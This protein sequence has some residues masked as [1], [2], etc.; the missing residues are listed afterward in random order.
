MSLL[1]AMA[2]GLPVVTTAEAGEIPEP[3]SA[4]NAVVVEDP[5]PEALARGM[6]KVTTSAKTRSELGRAAS[7]RAAEL[8]GGHALDQL[9]VLDHHHRIGAAPAGEPADGL[10]ALFGRRVRQ[11]QR[12]RRA[13]AL[14]PAQ[15]LLAGD[16]GA[17]LFGDLAVEA[18][19][20]DGLK[21]HGRS[22]EEF[23]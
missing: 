1:E 6:L 10:K 4:A 22:R 3:A 15:A 2:A 9:G 17:Q 21:R 8:D 18:A 14:G 13:D 19:R 5:R 16:Q 12:V 11:R 23:R 20:L 7:A